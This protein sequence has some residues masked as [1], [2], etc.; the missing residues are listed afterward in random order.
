MVEGPSREMVIVF[1]GKHKP[2]LDHDG[3]QNS[4]S[5]FEL[6][7]QPDGRSSEYALELNVGTDISASQRRMVLPSEPDTIRDPSGEN[8]TDLTELE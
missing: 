5:A 4:F 2:G 1:L 3:T 8:G 7:T 6:T